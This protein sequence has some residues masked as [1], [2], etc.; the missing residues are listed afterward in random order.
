MIDG[1][2]M[3]WAS[4]FNHLDRINPYTMQVTAKG[5]KDDINY[6]MADSQGYV[7]VAGNQEVTCFMP[8]TSSRTSQMESKTWKIGGKVVTMCDVD[9]KTWVV[10]GKVCS[11]IDLKGESYRFKIPSSIVPLT[12][13]YSQS[14]HLVMMGG[15]DGYVC[16]RPDFF[17]GK[18]E[19]TQLML[20]GMMVNGKQRQGV[21]TQEM[22]ELVLENDENS[23][24][25]Q[26]TD[27]PFSDH[28]SSVYA[29][30][31][32]G[33]DHEWHLLNKS[34]LDIGYN[35]LPYGNYHLVVH[36]VD[37]EGNMGAEVY[38]LDI[39]I[40]PPWYLSLWAKIVYFLLFVALV[41]GI[42]KFFLVRQRLAEERRQKT[43]ILEQ[44]EARIN[45]FTRLSEELKTAVTHRSFEEILYLTNRYLGVKTESKSVEEPSLS[46][47]DQKLLK[48][49]TE[50][51]EAHLI[52]TDFNVTTL[53]KVLCMNGK[54]LY[55]KLKTL[56]GKTPVEYIRE[57][58]MNKA[59]TML[60][61]GKFSVSE[62]MYSVGFSNSSYFSKCFSKAYGMTPTEY[63]KSE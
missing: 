45:F 50:A 9:G 2:G 46:A 8:K 20:M 44:V 11:V 47:A 31:L 40:L 49:I 34:R 16:L 28:P 30:R 38:S 1:Q 19:H 57:I 3:I 37:G 22:K 51:I 59:A 18:A 42:M 55:R 14:Q 25:L 27:L 41:W 60:K 53:Q 15:N 21:A 35:G 43:E 62:V 17:R 56:T 48:E 24:L 29:Y 63:M 39:K 5:D 36:V 54:Q 32:E 6:L 58:R 4:S 26:L 33:I 10:S 23:F 13:F 7:W 12:M 52:D 61:E